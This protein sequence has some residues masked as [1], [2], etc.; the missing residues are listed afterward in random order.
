MDEDD[1][2][3]E[4]GNDYYDE[5]DTFIDEDGEN[6]LSGGSIGDRYDDF[7]QHLIKAGFVKLDAGSFRVSYKRGK[8]VVKVPR[9][10]DG[11]LDNR[12]EARAWRKYKS[13]PSKRGIQYAPC[14]LLPNGCLMMVAVETY[15]DTTSREAPEYPV[16]G[17]RVEGEQVGL[18]RGKWIAYD[19]AW[20]VTERFKWEEEWKVKSGHFRD[21]HAERDYDSEDSPSSGTATFI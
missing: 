12:I 13:K 21:V 7:R 19:Y 2:Y 4:T 15:V 17:M 1:F 11:V 8:I 3:Y 16:W 20:D 5:D 9:N 6:G 14:R 18:Y 10:G